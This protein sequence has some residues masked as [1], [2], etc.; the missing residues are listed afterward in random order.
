M[1]ELDTGKIVA[2]KQLTT[3]NKSYYHFRASIY[4]EISIFLIETIKNIK[5]NKGFVNK[6]YDQEEKIA[7]YQKI[8]WRK[9]N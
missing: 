6:P 5:E 2:K 1:R 7:V 9:K 3:N 8:Y 4:K